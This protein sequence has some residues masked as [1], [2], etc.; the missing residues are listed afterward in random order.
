MDTYKNLLT[1]GQKCP[2]II[3]MNGNELIKKI[4]KL[5]KKNDVHVYFDKAHG[6]GS[7]GTLFYGG[8][9]TTI[10]DKKKE[11]GPGLLN[12]MLMDLEISKDDL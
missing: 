12:S 7:H 2:N 5:A 4:K 6:K 11:I 8:N 1:F 3:T 9:H 10:K